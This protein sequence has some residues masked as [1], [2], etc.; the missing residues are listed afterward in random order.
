MSKKAYPLRIPVGLLELAE[1]KGKD[2]R[3]DKTT[4]LRQWLYAGAEEYVLKM[5]SEGRLTLS[6]AA[7]LMDMSV[8]DVQRLAGERGIELGATAEQYEKARQT[9]RQ[10]GAS[11]NRKPA[12]RP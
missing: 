10:L 11:I 3:T 8:Y 4:A 7:A 9:A 6:Q 1:L 5:L 2:E 12:K